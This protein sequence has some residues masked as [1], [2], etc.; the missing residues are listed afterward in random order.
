MASVVVPESRHG[1]TSRQP[2]MTT[3]PVLAESCLALGSEATRLGTQYFAWAAETEELPSALEHD[4]YG[5]A[6]A[7][8]PTA[9]LLLFLLGAA[10]DPG[11]VRL[12]LLSQMLAENGHSSCGGSDSKWRTPPAHVCGANWCHGFSSHFF[13]S[14]RRVRMRTRR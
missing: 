4:E 7:D 14:T 1:G 9:L 11:D 6:R 10:T 13:P 2:V 8:Q 12:D 3:G 5:F